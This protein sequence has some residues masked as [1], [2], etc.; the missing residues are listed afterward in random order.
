[1][2]IV[3]A[4]GLKDWMSIPGADAVDDTNLN[5]AAAAA[6]D[7]VKGWCRRSFEDVGAGSES[8]RWFEALTPDYVL[9][10]DFHTATNLVVATDDNDDGTAET[11]WAAADYQLEPVNRERDGITWPFTAIS[12]VNG[13]C[14][15]KGRRLTQ[16]SV[17]ARWGFAETVPARVTEAGLIWGARLFRR[18]DTPDGIAGTAEFGQIRVNSRLDPDVEQMLVKFRKA[19]VAPGALLL[20][21]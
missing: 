7:A 5:T 9:V 19:Q 12:A 14:F 1:M 15:P 21:G 4:P 3:D 6:D 20:G 10:D 11:V 8:V 2:T 13:R 17:T 16:I 18:K